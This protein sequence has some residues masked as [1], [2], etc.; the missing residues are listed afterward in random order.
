MTAMGTGIAWIPI[1]FALATSF[2]YYLSTHLPEL[3]ADSKGD[4]I[5]FPSN[6]EELT[7]L[8]ATLQAY[9]VKHIGLVLLLFC[10]A[11]LYKQTFAIPGSV[12]MNLLAGALFGIWPGFPL[13]CILTACGATFCFLLSKTFGKAYVIHYFPDKV[14]KLQ[15]MVEENMESLFFFLLF[16]RLFPMSPNWFLNITSPILNIP[17][18]L[19]FLSVLIGLMPYNF[20]CVQTGCI[21][22]QINNVGDMLTYGT[23]LKLAAMALVA[24]LPGVLLKKYHTPKIPNNTVKR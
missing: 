13:T 1:I 9:K 8:A 20:L 7:S 17:I 5:K 24:L 22:S 23:L 18:H 6:I 4:E 3:P 15:H 10:S 16:L 14:A 11:Y 19:F 21:L 2:L 12:F